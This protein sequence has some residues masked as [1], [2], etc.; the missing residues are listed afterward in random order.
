MNYLKNEKGASDFLTLI[1]IA[2]AVLFGFFMLNEH[3]EKQAI[4]KF[5]EKDEI[6]NVEKANEKDG[7]DKK[8][9]FANGDVKYVNVKC[10]KETTESE[11]KVKEVD[12]AS[13]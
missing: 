7:W 11:C 10:E 1:M 5:Y 3:E 4:E 2:L 9:I 8:V 12:I 6:E 13:K